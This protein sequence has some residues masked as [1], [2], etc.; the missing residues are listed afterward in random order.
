VPVPETT[1]PAWDPEQGTAQPLLQYS[2]TVLD[3]GAGPRHAGYVLVTIDAGPRPSERIVPPAGEDYAFDAARWARR[4]EVTVS[5]KGRS[6]RVWVDGR[7][8]PLRTTTEQD[9]P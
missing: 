8:I 9:Q 2:A 1:R 7:E 3:E 5:P 4:V 6:A